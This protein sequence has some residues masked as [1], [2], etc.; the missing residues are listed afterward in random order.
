LKAE[1]ISNTQYPIPNLF[2]IVGPTAVGKTALAV[3]LARR[4]DGEIVSADSRQI[5]R[6]MDIG[7][8][9][10]TRQEQALA[11]H[12]LIDIVAPDEPYTLAQFQADAYAAI[13]G[14]LARG[15]LP[16]LVG[17]TGLYVRAVVE[18]LR[19]P[20]VPPNPELRAQLATQDGL[21]LYERLRELD[22]EAAAR[23]DPR[24]VRRTIRALEVCLTTGQRF[25]ELGRASPPPYRI[26]Q[27]GLTLSRPEL[28]ARI[29]A[30]V[31]RM[32]ADGLVSEVESLVAQ[33]FGWNLPSMSGLGYRE[34]GT[35]LRGEVSLNEAV[36]NI[37]RDTRDFVRRQYAWFRLKDERI[38]WFDVTEGGKIDRFV[39]AARGRGEA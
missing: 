15:K 28:Y 27:I 29:D 9:K 22:P 25:S 8:A 11:P 13:D 30:R 34:M 18:G 17:G 20:R 35:Y 31:D 4:L 7:T 12:H 3:E 24:N 10:P 32:M 1:Q 23:I 39:E 6:G 21:A 38:R 33:G 2:V 5:Y 16:L 36:A 14:I 19:I 37:K 26:T